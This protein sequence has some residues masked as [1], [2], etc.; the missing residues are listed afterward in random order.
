VGALAVIRLD[1]VELPLFVH[2]LGAL[3]LIGAISTAAVF[4]F[5]ARRDGSARLARTGFRTLLFAAIPSF[6]VMRVGAEWV[7]DKENIDPY[8]DAPPAWIDVGLTVSDI[9]LLLLVIATV[10]AGL[11]TRRAEGSIGRGPTL[12]AWLLSLLLVAYTVA[13]WAMATKPV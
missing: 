8:G 11:A 3:L 5:Q 1:E 10:A 2:I 6:I 7:S 4:L 12:A 9:G 13:V